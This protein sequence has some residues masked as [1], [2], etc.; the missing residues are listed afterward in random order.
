[1][2]L[3]HS[4]IARNAFFLRAHYATAAP[5]SASL[6]IRSYNEIPGPSGFPF[7]GSV[8]VFAKG[9]GT[10]RLPYIIDDLHKT[11]GPMFR[12]SLMG[13]KGVYLGEPSLVEQM[14]RQEQSDPRISGFDFFDK[15]TNEKGLPQIVIAAQGNDWRK[16]RRVFD[17]K[18]LAPK[19]ANMFFPEFNNIAVELGDYIDR[20]RDRST[21][22]LQNLDFALGAA[23]LESGAYVVFGKRIGVLS[24][25]DGGRWSG[26]IVQAREFTEKM[27]P[28]V[29]G[30]PLWRLFKTKEYKAW[31]KS[32]E[33]S[34]SSLDDLFEHVEEERKCPVTGVASNSNNAYTDFVTY[35]RQ[36]EDIPNA[37]LSIYALTVQFAA[38]D[39]TATHLLWT[40]A[41]LAHNPK[42]QEKLYEE[43]NGLLKGG[44]LPKEKIRELPFLKNVVRESFRIRPIASAAAR[45]ATE[46]RLINGYLIPKGTAMNAS[47]WT[48]N[49]SPKIWANPE[50]FDPS[51]HSNPEIHPFSLLP[52]SFG[53][54]A[55]PGQ[56][57]SLN[58]TY[59]VLA[60]LIQ[61]YRIV[62][63]DPNSTVPDATFKL[64]MSPKTPVNVRFIPRSQQ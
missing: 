8:Q 63:V 43:L 41:L 4:R 9:G 22:E 21:G 17:Q 12:M 40:V 57:I 31:E 24:D 23:A 53:S 61:R 52:F 56:R 35:L 19:E 28:L 33:T 20:H 25:G 60:H 38:I 44:P 58:E 13:Q 30:L 27:R 47:F 45:L 64:V 36:K 51:R 39:T 34:M 18:I 32:I 26:M 48:M 1:M 7:L 10:E 14:Y 46:D 49:F 50:V 5:V 37:D 6:G 42:E 54:R 15:Y 11:Y 55:C 29:V 3:A 62:P 59:C 16:I 2:A